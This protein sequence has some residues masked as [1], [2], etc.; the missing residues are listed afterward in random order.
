MSSCVRRALERKRVRVERGNKNKNTTFFSIH[1]SKRTISR[2]PLDCRLQIY[3]HGLHNLTWF[4]SSESGFHLAAAGQKKKK[5]KNKSAC[6]TRRKN[7]QGRRRETCQ[8]QLCC[9]SSQNTVH[10]VAKWQVNLF[11]V[12]D[13]SAGCGDQ[14]SGDATTP[15][16]TFSFLRSEWRP[17]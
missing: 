2:M 4:R 9:F 1:I 3:Y 11:C 17:T 7:R 8:N 5:K 10:R 14:Q 12:P 13:F 16:H 6:T 15:P